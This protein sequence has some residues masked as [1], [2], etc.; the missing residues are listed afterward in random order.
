MVRAGDAGIEYVWLRRRIKREVGIVETLLER[1]FAAASKSSKAEQ[2]ILASRLPGAIRT[3]DGDTVS[4]SG[5]DQT[6]I[7]T[8]C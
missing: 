5:S 6:P 2:D 8:T 7:T 3:P 1:A 4:G